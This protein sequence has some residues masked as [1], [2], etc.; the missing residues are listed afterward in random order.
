[1]TEMTQWMADLALLPDI[2]MDYW[3]PFC[4]EYASQTCAREDLPA[5]LGDLGK[6]SGW[7][8]ETGRVVMLDNEHIELELRPL[9]A[10]FFQGE[11]AWQLSLLPGG[12]WQL[13]TH[14]LTAC[15]AADATHLG[16]RVEHLL[17][18]KRG[19]RLQYWRLWGPA[20][21]DAADCGAPQCRIAL[22]T[23]IK[24]SRA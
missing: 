8:K 21:S 11:T 15:S 5:L 1:M 10:E 14:R 6:V 17:A 3:Q 4:H 22:L 7:I 20:E 2:D 16:E 9:A 23:G 13:H 12:R 18:G 19:G 24:E